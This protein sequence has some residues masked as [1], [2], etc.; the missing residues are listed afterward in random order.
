[1]TRHCGRSLRTASDLSGFADGSIVSPGAQHP[2][3]NPAG[4][5]RCGRKAPVISITSKSRYAVVA[6]AELA[7]SGERPVPIKELAERRGIPEQFLEQ[8]FSTLRRAGLLTSHRGM[9]GGYTLSRAGRGDHRARGRPGARRQGRPGG[10]RGGRHLGRGRHRPAQGLRP[11]HDR[12]SRPPRGR[13]G[14]LA[15]CT[16]SSCEGPEDC[17][18]EARALGLDT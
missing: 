1:M 8:L 9:R 12:R 7:R 10:R 3:P 11:D 15:A 4:S 5:G 18:S 13:G 16:S 2:D 6:M 17:V 14:R